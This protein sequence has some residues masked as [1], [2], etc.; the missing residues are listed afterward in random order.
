MSLLADLFAEE[1]LDPGYAEAAA[2]RS[3]AREPGVSGGSDAASSRVR[4][5]RR[6]ARGI[7]M[8]TVLAAAGL[9]AATAVVQARRVEPVANNQRE[10]LIAEIRSRAAQGVALQRQ[11]DDLRARTR[12]SRQRALTRD[13][14]GR[15]ARRQLDRAAAEAAAT[16]VRGPGLVVV[17]GDAKPGSGQSP[18][19]EADAGR[20]YDRD[21][22]QLVNGLWAA[23][24]EAIAINGQR[25]A[26][27]TAIRSA[28]EAI[29][30]DFRPLSPP[31][32]VTAVGNPDLLRPAFAASA[33]ARHLRTL[34]SA[35]GIRF[36]VR[37]ER[38]VR[39]PAA[40]A[41]G[42]RHARKGAGK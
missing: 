12:Q 1:G 29:L 13:E 27:S 14:A 21:L 5:G 30:V 17:V 23:G 24:A 40:G 11:I 3:R 7:R 2:R 41:L 19:G 20:L 42:L 28:G 34:R 6:V 15:A 25:L 18:P 22:Q 39:L 26:A 31:Y 4:P 32:E 9:L 37:T 38:E 36:D 8:F 10:R 35:V 16:P 33:E